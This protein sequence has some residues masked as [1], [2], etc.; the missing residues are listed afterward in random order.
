MRNDLGSL[1]RAQADLQGETKAR[2]AVVTEAGAESNSPE[3]W[4]FVDEKIGW[5]LA[6]HRIYSAPLPVIHVVHTCIL[7]APCFIPKAVSEMPVVQE[8][9]ALLYIM[10]VREGE[11]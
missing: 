7:R 11:R 9:T 1:P 10:K 8:H 5:I 3:I 6:R 4:V 2:P